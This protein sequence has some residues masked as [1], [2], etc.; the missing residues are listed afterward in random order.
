[1]GSVV[2]LRRVLVHEAHRS[3]G[4]LGDIIAYR[5]AAA[6]ANDTR[7][8]AEIRVDELMRRILHETNALEYKVWIGG[9]DNF[10]YQIY[11]EYKAHRKDKPKPIWLDACREHLVRYWN[12]RITEGNE[13]DDEL[14]IEQSARGYDSVICTI[15]KDLLQVPGHH[16]NFVK[17][18]ERF[19]SPYDGLRFFYSQLIT[20]DGAD[21]IPAFDGKFRDKQPKFVQKLLDPLSEITDEI[22][23]LQHVRLV[24]QDHLDIDIDISE[25]DKRILRNGQCLWIQRKENDLWQFPHLDES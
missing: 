9:R 7:D 14:G 2:P 19:V 1:M 8:I 22:D 17:N 24:Y 13:T 21:H 15:D 23:M 6:S 4:R 5:C 11:P 25:I 18:E 12:C 16:Y 3:R 20:G 10:R